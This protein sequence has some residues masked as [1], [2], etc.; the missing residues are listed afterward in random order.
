MTKICIVD[1]YFIITLQ[2]EGVINEENELRMLN[3]LNEVLR[4]KQSI[5]D[6]SIEAAI[7]KASRIEGWERFSPI[8][9]L[10]RL[11][12]LRGR[13]FAMR[14]SLPLLL[15]SAEIEKKK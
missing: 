9:D 3:E 10:D 14:A 13:E 2:T 11:V 6:A 15:R 8:L 12:L 7:E 5:L 4:Q 1:Y